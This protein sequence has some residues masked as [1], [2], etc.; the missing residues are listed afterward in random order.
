MLV[1][2]VEGTGRQSGRLVAAEPDPRSVVIGSPDFPGWMFTV[3]FGE[4]GDVTGFSIDSRPAEDGAHEPLNA[5]FVHRVPV[6]TIIATARARAAWSARRQAWRT[7]KL[8]AEGDSERF[9]ELL[10]EGQPAEI[11]QWASRARPRSPLSGVIVSITSPAKSSSIEKAR[12]K[13]TSQSG[14]HANS[15]AAR[16]SRGV[17]NGSFTRRSP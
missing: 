4:L 14:G 6:G 15:T 12:T 1:P 5:A 17:I 11:Q 9:A 16:R 10:A 13:C 8:G 3:T 2:L 7:A